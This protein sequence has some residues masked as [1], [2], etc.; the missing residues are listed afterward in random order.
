MPVTFTAFS[1]EL[2]IE[3]Q[4]SHSATPPEWKAYALPKANAN[5]AAKATLRSFMDFLRTAMGAAGLRKTGC[6]PFGAV[7]VPAPKDVGPTQQP[8]ITCN[9]EEEGWGKSPR[10]GP[11]LAGAFPQLGSAP[12]PW[13]GT[14]CSSCGR[15]A[16]T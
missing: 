14:C 1:N 11:S 8:G 7:V 12:S 13:R 2:C 5:T 4:P 3:W 6:Q 10:P 15:T 9:R 16:R